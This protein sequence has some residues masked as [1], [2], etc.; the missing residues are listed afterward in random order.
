M[1]YN[2][3]YACNRQLGFALLDMA[4]HT[5]GKDDE[6]DIDSFEEEATK[7]TELLPPV[8]GSN[9]SCS[10][11]HLFSGGYAAGYYGYKWSE[12]LDADAFSLFR[13]KGIFDTD[14]A[15]SFRKNILEKGASSEPM[16]MYRRFR[17]K[18]PSLEAFLNRS[19][20]K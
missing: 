11:G 16:E 20:F 8:E 5:F 9:M 19:G 13:E 10:F 12:V 2:E 4:W 3:G 7:E 14:T 18:E 1:T 6:I 15:G 17:G